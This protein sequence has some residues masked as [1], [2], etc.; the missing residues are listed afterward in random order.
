MILLYV[1]IGSALGGVG[2]FLLGPFVQSR[3]GGHFPVGTFV[4]NVS[5][6]FALGFLAKMA[7]ASPGMSPAA[8]AYLMVGFCGGY[9]TFSTFS[10][11]TVELLERGDYGR[12]SWY[13]LASVIVSLAATIAGAAAARELTK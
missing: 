11:E 10:L 6:A 1:A 7:L 4:V 13:V 3:V 8:R 5:G 2:R 12:A 9:T